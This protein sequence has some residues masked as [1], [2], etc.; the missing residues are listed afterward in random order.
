MELGKHKQAFADLEAVQ[1]LDPQN[2]EVYY[3]RG[4]AY[5]ELEKM[6]EAFDDYTT[7]IQ[8]DPN[9]EGKETELS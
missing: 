8:L 3:N 2:P 4:L 1:K 7:T 9:H 5:E 6:K